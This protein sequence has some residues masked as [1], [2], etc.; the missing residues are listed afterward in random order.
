[1][2][3]AGGLLGKL[4]VV[5]DSDGIS[6]RWAEEVVQAPAQDEGLLVDRREMM[7][8]FQ[9]HPGIQEPTA[10]TTGHNPIDHNVSSQSIGVVQATPRHQLGRDHQSNFQPT[11]V[12]DHP[13]MMPW[14]YLLCGDGPAFFPAAIGLAHL[15]EMIRRQLQVP[16]QQ[17]LR[18]LKLQVHKGR[19]CRSLCMPEEVD[20]IIDQ[21]ASRS[22]EPCLTIYLSVVRQSRLFLCLHLCV[23][24]HV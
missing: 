13:D 11:A 7:L 15:D 6:S 5:V 22:E 2:G 18:C 23:L 19:P 16:L 12:S 9:R 3:R 4:A 17:T 24:S 10:M 1:M 20:V 21:L 8:K 14:K